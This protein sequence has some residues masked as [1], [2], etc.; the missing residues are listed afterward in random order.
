MGRRRGTA[1]QIPTVSERAFQSPADRPAS[2]AEV[3]TRRRARSDDEPVTPGRVWPDIL[4]GAALALVTAVVY[5]PARFFEFVAIDDHIYVTANQHVLDGL[6]WL[7]ATWAFSTT[8]ANFW[9]PLT[10]LSLMADASVF[11]AGPFGFHLTNVILHTLSTVLLYGALVRMTEC[12]WQSAFAAALFAL[13]PLHVESV[14]WVS[15]R[16]DVLSAFFLMATLLAYAEFARR[17]SWVAYGLAMA[18]FACGLLAKPM[19]VTLPVTLLLLDIWP[20][21][22]LDIG[23]DD[24]SLE[25]GSVP[26]TTRPMSPG[27]AIREKLPFFGL[28]VVVGVLAVVAQQQGGALGSTAQFPLV[29]RISNALVSTATYLLKTVWPATLVPFYPYPTTP[30]W[31]AAFAS[32]AIIGTITLLAIWKVR[33]W[34][35]VAVGWFWYL[36]TLAPVSGILQVG[37]H[38]MADRYTYVPLVG[39][40]VVVACGLTELAGRLRVPAVLRRVG[41]VALLLA[42]VVVTRGQLGSWRNTVTLFEHTLAVMPDNYYAHNGLGLELDKQERSSDARQHF[43][44]ATELAPG[45]PN[46]RTNL[47]TILVREGRTAEARSLL[48]DAIRVAPDYAPA[49]VGLGIALAKAGRAE[50]AA[51]LFSEAVRLDPGS[52]DAHGGLANALAAVG[53]LEAAIPEYREAVRLGPTPEVRNNLGATLMRLDRVNEAAVEFRLAIEAAPDSARAHNNLGNAFLMLHQP[54]EAARHYREAIRFD[55]NFADAHMNLG[56]A[57]ADVNLLQEALA[58]HRLAVELNPTSPDTH[59]NLGDTLERMGSLR[60]AGAQFAEVLRLRPDDRDAAA[61]AARLLQRR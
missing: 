22:R 59:Y 31:G 32:T 14:A 5:A 44:R 26:A 34:P 46:A 54:A 57:L 37:S 4:I 55:R 8:F 15:E 51:T 23:A 36:I 9:H 58:E 1:R 50:E 7:G 35:W 49:R 52:A 53:R 42:C 40:F 47:A 20:L 28:S 21:R 3:P 60:E 13:H 24:G 12:R 45:V 6:S 10:W 11:G 25:I 18:C 29:G 19:L 30:A 56:N 43:A 33:R 41:A 27:E 16:K 38:A 48:E 39:V 61:R 17:R 2:A